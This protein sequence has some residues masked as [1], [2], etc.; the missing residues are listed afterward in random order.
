MEFPISNRL[1]RLG[2]YAFDELGNKVKELEEQGV[3]VIDFGVGDPRYPTPEFIRKAAQ[4]G[5]DHYATAGYPSYAGSKQ[6]RTVVAQWMQQRFNVSLNPDTE[7]MA[8]I[9]SKEAIFN[10]PEAV[11]NPGDMVLAPTPGYPPYRTGAAFAEGSVYLYPLLPENAYLPDWSSFPPDVLEKA[12][13][14]WISY[15]NSPTGVMAPDSFYREAVAFASQHN[16]ILASDEA[17]S[18]L[19]FSKTPARSALEF[20]RDGVVVFQ[21]LSKRSAMTGY[22]VGFLCGDQRIVTA[23]RKLKT[24]IDS[25][26]PDFIQGAA[27]AALND[28]EHVHEARQDYRRKRDLIINAFKEAGIEVTPP[29]GTIYIWQKAPNGLTDVEWAHR[30]LDPSI[31]IAVMPGS[32]LGSTASDGSNPGAGFVRWALCPMMEDVELAAGRIKSALS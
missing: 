32:W 1:N 9:G 26:V 16:L 20:G 8:T 23:V 22:R 12:R 15:P 18:E 28:E 19:Y 25:G 11:L 29:E 30:L 27:M 21:S 4:A 5:I 31:A 2:G 24:N 6:F 10:F 14:L 7:I 3:K 17:Y 13:I